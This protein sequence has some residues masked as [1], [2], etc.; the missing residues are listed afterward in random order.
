MRH[1]PNPIKIYHLTLWFFLVM[2]NSANSA[3]RQA[4]ILELKHQL[5]EQ[6]IP[7]IKPLLHKDDAI[8]SF[9]NQLILN[10]KTSTFNEI[11]KLVI[12]LDQPL[13]NLIIFVR[14]N[15][16]VNRSLAPTGLSGKI[17]HKDITINTG[18]EHSNTQTTSITRN[19]LVFS[20]GKNSKTYST[21][22]SQSIRTI[23]GRPAYI[24]TGQLLPVTTQNHHGQ[25]TELV[26]ALKGFYITTRLINDRVL[27]DI[28]T[29]HDSM[30]QKPYKSFN[31]QAINTKRLS[32]TI[33]GKLG[34]WI[35]LG[36][37]TLNNQ[38]D[39]QNVIRHSQTKSSSLGDIALKVQV[40]D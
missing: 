40:I 21:H 8:T 12:Q 33:S 37:I 24:A 27:L 9:R 18:S 3:E 38:T 7:T 5:P 36:G 13:H 17:K 35:S 11:K 39:N 20:I 28:S 4:F 10:T 34:E 32:T 26:S 14:N 15:S 1:Y 30:S 23:E 31:T 22:N 2:V 6:I 25:Q 19:G 29:T 16:Q